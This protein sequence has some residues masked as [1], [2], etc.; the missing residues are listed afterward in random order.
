MASPL[1]LARYLSRSLVSESRPAAVLWRRRALS[2]AAAAPAR[3]VSCA[4]ITAPALTAAGSA[5][6]ASA[7]TSAP[8][9]GSLPATSTA[10]AAAS[11][12]APSLLGA[13]VRVRAWVKS[14]RAQK[15][16]AFLALNDGS[17]QTGVQ[18]TC[19]AMAKGCVP[20]SL[21]VK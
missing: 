20:I 12:A 10:A 1:R 3:I 14:A 7:S 17:G 9:P 2:S 13:R 11:S 6:S 4:D 18:V 5:A 16:M 15:T 19:P 21:R 8:A